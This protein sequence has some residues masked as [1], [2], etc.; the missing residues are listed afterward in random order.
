MFEKT[1]S[2]AYNLHKISLTESLFILPNLGY[3]PKEALNLKFVIVRNKSIDDDGKFGVSLTV[4]IFENLQKK[5][6]PYLE[7]KITMVGEFQM[8]DLEGSKN[9]DLESFC[10]INAPAIIYPYIRQH[11]RALT[12]DAGFTNPIVLPIINFLK[13]DSEIKTV[14]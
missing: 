1:Y 2:A 10:R 9:L 6:T 12:L 5:E 8:L 13:L 7:I 14:N 11:V 4:E 3:E